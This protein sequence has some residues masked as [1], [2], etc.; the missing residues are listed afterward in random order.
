MKSRRL[1]SITLSAVLAISPVMGNF[2]AGGV[3]AS[4]A[5][6]VK[7]TTSGSSAATPSNME[8]T[9]A[10]AAAGTSAANAT[11]ST[12]SAS[13][14]TAVS[15]AKATATDLKLDSAA[16]V[17]ASEMKDAAAQSVVVSKG[18]EGLSKLFTY[19]TDEEIEEIVDLLTKGETFEGHAA[20]VVVNDV[21]LSALTAS[22]KSARSS[23]ATP[24]DLSDAGLSAADL[25]AADLLDAMGIDPDDTQRIN[26]V[27][28]AEALINAGEVLFEDEEEK[29]KIISVY[30]NNRAAKYLVRV[31]LADPRVVS[32]EPNYVYDAGDALSSVT[33]TGF[34]E[35]PSGSDLSAGNAAAAAA[36]GGTVLSVDPSASSA[37][38][39]VLAAV[40]SGSSAGSSA[41]G[42]LSAYGD[43][44]HFQ[45]AYASN[46]ADILALNRNYSQSATADYMDIKEG[47]NIHLEDWS[48]GD[49]NSEGVIAIVDT[50]VDYTHPDLKDV[51][52]HFSPELQKQLGCTEFGKAPVDPDLKDDPMDDLDHGTHIA[53]IIA[54]SWDGHGVSGVAN[55]AK[56]IAVKAAT[57]FGT[58]KAKDTIASFNFVLEAKKA[59]VD[60]RLINYSAAT[61][62]PAC[63]PVIN[64]LGKEGILIIQASGNDDL[65]VDVSYPQYDQLYNNPY[66]IKVNS[67]NVL[68]DRMQLS[69]KVGKA[70]ETLGSNYGLKTDIFAPGQDMV[71]AITLHRGDYVENEFQRYYPAA[72]PDAIAADS[73]DF[74]SA[75]RYGS[76]YNKD[77]KGVKVFADAEYD[78]TNKQ[79][80]FKDAAG[81]YT[82]K[83]IGSADSNY[84][85]DDLGGSLRIDAAD[86]KTEGTGK[87]FVMAVPADATDA[88]E[89]KVKLAAFGL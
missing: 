41:G 1:I 67:S 61:L 66:I 3:L 17:N 65:N 53:G 28:E 54:G 9:A 26:K 76:A 58:L 62:T 22:A 52:Y 39:S 11:V 84:C 21:D 71:S 18:I 10:N 35:N 25:Q 29:V 33:S 45:Y 55:G 36:S 31:L 59:G 87:S 14:A 20:L 72:D 83:P 64:A 23:A 56:L 49:I 40:T 5:D 69:T 85:Y 73:F 88:N 47:N 63:L 80:K 37:D 24:T 7:L 4:F 44:T 50:G 13:A 75:G 32:A 15:A 82:D 43:I 77:Y 74:T 89:A 8:A 6:T 30:N 16:D 79:W 70:T 51:M 60:I 86:M 34:T 19:R 12:A 68:R 81:S 2:P 27:K 78:S 46:A 57:R 48:D 42:V 38:S